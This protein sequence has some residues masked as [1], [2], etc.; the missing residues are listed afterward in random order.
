[1]GYF[2]NAA[3]LKPLLHLW[4]LAV[5]EQ[6]YIFWPLMLG[7]AWRRKWRFM[8]MFG[9]VAALSFLLN[10]GTIHSHRIAAFYSP[11][12]RFW[13]LMLGAGLAYLRLYR[14]HVLVKRRNLQSVAGLALIVLGLVYIRADKAFPGW[15]AL[16]PTVGA[17]FCISAGP[18]AL[19]NR[20]LLGARPLVWIGLISYPLYL[21]HWPLLSFAQIVVGGTPSDGVRTGLMAA[22]VLLAWLTYR[23][24][25]RPARKAHAPGV[26]RVLG[27]AV[28]CLVVLGTLA[29]TGRLSGRLGDAY[30]D[31]VDQARKNWTYGPGMTPA[32]LA[33][34]QTVYKIG[35][36]KERVLLLGDSH[37]EQYGIRA[38][39]LAK[40]PAN[41]LN[42]ITFAT[43]A[44]CPFVPGI[45][46]DATPGCDEIRTAFLDH[47]LT[48]DVDTIVIGGCWNCYFID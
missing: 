33:S 20:W 19:L 1:A 28:A 14:P 30:F 27:V 41:A 40:D 16:L 48:D 39:Q 38:V 12:T 37:T 17:F 45:F 8:T 21:W 23:F 7:L 13:E 15:W 9:V 29:W 4:S 32:R 5:E 26:V 35:T 43:A 2:D 25:E 3:E 22:A 46:R 42:S 18:T 34:G 24:V 31:V 6:F 11:A 44:G 10:V 36:G 47:G